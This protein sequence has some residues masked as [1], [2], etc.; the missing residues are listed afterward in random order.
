MRRDFS[1]QILLLS[2]LGKYYSQS[3]ADTFL[4]SDRFVVHEIQSKELRQF[5]IYKMHS[6]S[7]LE[8]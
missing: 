6:N 3:F 8:F 1:F 7:N 4:G 5:N 2:K